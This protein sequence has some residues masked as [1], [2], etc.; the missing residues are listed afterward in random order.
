M[1]GRAAAA[2][3][4]ASAPAHCCAGMYGAPRCWLH[5][6]QACRAGDT[7]PFSLPPILPWESKAL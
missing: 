5:M 1:Q 3:G 2:W 6:G 4:S 7:A